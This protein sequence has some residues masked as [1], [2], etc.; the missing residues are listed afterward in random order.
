MYHAVFF[1]VKNCLSVLLR[2]YEGCAVSNV[3]L[4]L[5]VIKERAA[6]QWYRVE[7]VIMV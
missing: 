6:T 3:W 1:T 5:E 2:M 7:K 4:S